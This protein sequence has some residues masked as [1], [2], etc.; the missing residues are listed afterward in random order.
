MSCVQYGP[1]DKC[2]GGII[3]STYIFSLGAP[4]SAAETAP[5]G[6]DG[7]TQIP[8]RDTTIHGVLVLGTLPGAFP[9]V[10]G[11]PPYRAAAAPIPC[12]LDDGPLA[13]VLQGVDSGFSN[14]SGRLPSGFK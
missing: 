2:L 13:C 10:R 7:V 1:K 5:L 8:K 9:R 14:F 12:E 3:L 4:S 6:V 11:Y